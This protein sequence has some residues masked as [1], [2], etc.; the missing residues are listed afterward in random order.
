[1][2][3]NEVSHLQVELGD[4]AVLGSPCLTANLHMSTMLYACEGKLPF[5]A[6]AIPHAPDLC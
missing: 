1:M 4:L 5:L 2:T 6:S 3:L